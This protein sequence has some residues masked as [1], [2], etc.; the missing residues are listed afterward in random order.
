[1]CEMFNAYEERMEMFFTVNNIVEITGKGSAHANRVVAE[2]K[3]AIFLTEV[4]AES[5]KLS[6]IHWRPLNPQI[7]HS[8]I[9]YGSWRSITIQNRWKLRKVSILEPEIRSPK[10]LL[11][12]T[13]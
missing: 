12:I 9:L 2:R 4:A 13:C 7:H 10:N 8:L 3:Q 5:I 11:G 1:M 6:V